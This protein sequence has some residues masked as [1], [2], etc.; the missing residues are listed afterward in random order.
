MHIFLSLNVPAQIRHNLN[1][2]WKYFSFFL[3]PEEAKNVFEVSVVCEVVMRHLSLTGG[4][5]SP[6]DKNREL[7]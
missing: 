4:S 2:S 5:C 3:N 7:P 6:E 1:F